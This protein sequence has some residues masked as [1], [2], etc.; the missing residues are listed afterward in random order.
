MKKRSII[1]ILAAVI[2]VAALAYVFLWP[3]PLYDIAWLGFGRGEPDTV[4]IVRDAFGEE[5]PQTYDVMLSASDAAA[6]LE[7]MRDASARFPIPGRMGNITPDFY[8][9]TLSNQQGYWTE[10]SINSNGAVSQ[11]EPSN[12][13]WGEGTFLL[14][15]KDAEKFLQI[16][17]EWTSPGGKYPGLAFLKEFFAI[18]K[19][20]RS[21][22]VRLDAPDDVYGAGDPLTLYDGLEDYMTEHGFN[23]AVM[24]RSLY[25][26]EYLCKQKGDGWRCWDIVVAPASEPG[27]YSYRVLLVEESSGNSENLWVTGNYYAGEDGLVDRFYV[28]L[29]GVLPQ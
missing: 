22:N 17:R 13:R 4:R 19:D 5:D 6:F 10:I 8:R 25:R 21:D 12:R 9:I 23:E 26:L 3:H 2:C 16:C 29:E 14:Y 18:G 20:G 27:Y 7:D 28:D 24:G 1:E 15:R 11:E